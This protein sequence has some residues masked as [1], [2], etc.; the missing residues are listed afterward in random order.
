MPVGLIQSLYT[1]DEFYRDKKFHSIRVLDIEHPYWFNYSQLFQI[2]LCIMPFKI[3]PIPTKLNDLVKVIGMTKYTQYIITDGD[4]KSW[5]SHSA[6]EV[7]TR[8]DRKF[9]S[10]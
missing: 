5:D 3:G 1:M 7:F 6:D 2:S 10:P 8:S 9:G 4:Y